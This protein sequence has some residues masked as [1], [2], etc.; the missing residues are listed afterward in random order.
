VQKPNKDSTPLRDG[1]VDLETGVVEPSMSPELR[2]QA[3]FRDR[4]IGVVRKGHPLSVGRISPARYASGRHIGVSRDAAQDPIDA[5]LATLD[6][7]RKIAVSL[8]AGFSLG[9]PISS[10]ACPSGTPESCGPA[11]LVSPS[12]SP[13]R[14]SRFP[15]CGTRDSMP[16]PA[17][18]GC[19][20][21]CGTYALP[22]AREQCG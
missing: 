19:A 18:A 2:T 7:R 10:P 1:T 13:R 4:Y 20:A 17:I 3:L 16:I 12:R 8:V 22:S 6:L 15:W 14:S 9:I 5:A 11:C 21:T